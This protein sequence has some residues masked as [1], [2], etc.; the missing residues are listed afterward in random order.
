MFFTKKDRIDLLEIIDRKSRNEAQI[1]KAEF[2]GKLEKRF[3]E[4]ENFYNREIDYL[5]KEIDAQDEVINSIMEQFT[6]IVAH[7]TKK[8]KPKSG[9]KV[10][11]KKK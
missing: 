1:S 6:E 2:E 5:F 10:L 7:L 11:T 9:Q 8:V 4:F 3:I